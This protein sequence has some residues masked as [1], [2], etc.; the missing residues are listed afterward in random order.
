M[1][2]K[3]RVAF[4]TG[5]ARGIGR[6]IAEEL[7]ARGASVAL[8]DRDILT[9]E[10]T[11]ATLRDGDERAIACELD[12]R[13]RAQWDAVVGD[14]EAELGP[15]D[16]LINNAG[17][18]AIGQYLE[19]DEDVDRLQMEVNLMGV[20]HG[21]RAVVPQMVKRGRGH[22]VNIA[23]VAGKIGT[24]FIAS[25]SAA[26][27]GVVG[28]TDAVGYELKDTGVKFTVV[29]PSLVE[30]ELISGTGRPKWPA[31]VTPRAVAVATARAIVKEQE[32]VFVPRFGRMS[33]VLPALLGRRLARKIGEALNV[34]EMFNEVDGEGR[35]AYRR[36][37]FG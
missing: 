6:A 9:A 32:E 26:K 33:V 1:D 30:T 4:V 15:V 22:V 28:M 37:I 7:V 21:M 36:R 17:I 5:G 31:P 14:V 18:M 24:P 2:V 11:A 23:S 10:R 25:Y 35:E 20:L 8:A 3:G 13:D 27:H 16:I 34:A 19:M 12:V 29:M